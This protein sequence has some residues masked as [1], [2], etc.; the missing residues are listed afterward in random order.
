MINVE[1]HDAAL[2]L[3]FFVSCFVKKIKNEQVELTFLVFLKLFASL[4]FCVLV[5]TNGCEFRKSF[6]KLTVF[7][8]KS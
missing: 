1:L 3:F 2:S 5:L 6:Y 4:V 8:C 7:I